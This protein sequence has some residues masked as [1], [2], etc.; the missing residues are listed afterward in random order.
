VKVENQKAIEADLRWQRIVL[1]D[2]ENIPLGLLL[3]WAS[4]LSSFNSQ[5]HNICMIAFTLA[6]IGHTVVYAREA[7]PHRAICWF[8]AVVSAFCLGLNGVLGVL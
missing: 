1:N 5:V 8:V 2:L 4:L 7:Q 6:R 3:A